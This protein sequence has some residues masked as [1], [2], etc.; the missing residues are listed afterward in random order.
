M[1]PPPPQQ[2][3]AWTPDPGTYYAQA[4]AAEQRARVHQHL[5]PLG[6]MWCIY[7]AYRILTILIG[8]TFLHTM[9][10][11]GMFGNMPD[12]VA[13]LIHAA[14]P[15][16][17]LMAVLM[18]SLAIL[19]GYALLTRQNWGRILAIVLAILALIKI[20][21]GTGLGIYTL[22]VLAPQASG[23]EWDQLT[24]VQA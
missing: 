7:G 6:I 1:P 13:H 5:Q 16:L 23:V 15:A 4:K 20:P 11:D 19:T 3:P 21:F 22:W 9:A 18:G 17:G 14:I 24:R 12:P 10:A 2:Q 8:L